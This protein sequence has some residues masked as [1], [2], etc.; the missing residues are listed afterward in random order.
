M[1]TDCDVLADGPLGHASLIERTGDTTGATVWFS[2]AAQT[3]NSPAGITIGQHTFDWQCW[4]TDDGST[5]IPQL[6]SSKSYYFG[7]YSPNNNTH[8]LSPETAAGPMT[9]SLG[10]RDG[11]STTSGAQQTSGVVLSSLS[12]SATW[13]VPIKFTYANPLELV[14]D[15]NGMGV[16]C[17]QSSEFDSNYGCEKAFLDNSWD[18]ATAG[19]GVNSWIDFTAPQPIPYVRHV[20]YRNRRG[21]AATHTE[22]NKDFSVAFTLSDG[23]V[24]TR[25]YTIPNDESLNTWPA[26]YANVVHVKI[27]VTGVYTTG[28][29]GADYVALVGNPYAAVW[30]MP[31]PVVADGSY[32]NTTVRLVK[33]YTIDFTFGLHPHAATGWGSLF[34]ISNSPDA[35][36]LDRTAAAYIYNHGN[37]RFTAHM[38][39]RTQ[40]N[41]NA[42]CDPPVNL[43]SWT[44]YTGSVSTTDSLTTMTVNGVS[45]SYANPN[46]WDYNSVKFYHGSPAF[47]GAHGLNRFRIT[48]RSIM[49]TGGSSSLADNEQQQEQQTQQSVKVGNN[50]NIAT[51]T[52][53]DNNKTQRG[54]G[55]VVGMVGGLMFVAVAVVV[56]VWGIC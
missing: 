26:G 9:I 47:P 42:Y 55:M 12:G 1:F 11:T 51:G 45:C 18:W 52:T 33:P 32:S 16:A 8:A 4:H 15:L 35:A 40:T 43:T 19:E 49:P 34:Y 23:T 46:A 54:G 14:M 21:G 20:L 56:V 5:S 37:D 17:G 30:D 39:A 50:N 24:A 7:W 13:T 25:T 27:T 3:Y 28:N 2:A 31:W 29:N 36:P 53:H 22:R 38:V 41:G 48:H 10:I 6:S 44:L